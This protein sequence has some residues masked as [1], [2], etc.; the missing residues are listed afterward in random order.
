MWPCDC[1]R[2]EFARRGPF[3][4]SRAVAMP[5]GCVSPACPAA[6]LGCAALPRSPSGGAHGAFAERCRGTPEWTPLPFSRPS[7]FPCACA[8]SMATPKGNFVAH[9]RMRPGLLARRSQQGADRGPSP[10]F[11]W[12]ATHERRCRFHAGSPVFAPRSPWWVSSTCDP[13]PLRVMS[14]PCVAPVLRWAPGSHRA[15][16]ACA[17]CAAIDRNAAAF[18][19]NTH[20]QRL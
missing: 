18:L 7:R 14:A 9:A 8:S 15:R 12:R 20:R 13:Q 5:G 4:P 17:L 11:R 10:A 3:G 19:T 2:C 16:P 6:R 1:C